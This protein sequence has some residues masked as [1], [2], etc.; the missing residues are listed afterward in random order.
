MSYIIEFTNSDIPRTGYYD[1]KSDV[2]VDDPRDAFHYKTYREARAVAGCDLFCY[3]SRIGQLPDAKIQVGQKKTILFL[4]ILLSATSGIF[5]AV[6]AS[7]IIVPY[8]LNQ[9]AC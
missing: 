4:L 9:I 2:P 7:A 3:K 5:G 6:I 8:L 1:G